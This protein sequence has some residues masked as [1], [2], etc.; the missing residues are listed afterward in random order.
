[1]I[2]KRYGKDFETSPPYEIMD[3]LAHVGL[4]IGQTPFTYNNTMLHADNKFCWTAI[5]NSLIRMAKNKTVRRVGS[6]KY[7]VNQKQARTY[8]H[9]RGYSWKVTKPKQETKT[10]KTTNQKSKRPKDLLSLAILPTI[11]AYV[12]HLESTIDKL[13]QPLWAKNNPDLYRS[14][15]N[16]NVSLT[17]QVGELKTLITRLKNKNKSLVEGLK[18]ILKS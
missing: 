7:I 5:K 8:L 3:F 6:G 15:K 18:N 12:V 4:E 11:A 17:N 9:D 1:M 14:L 10:T 16:E 2:V 13:R